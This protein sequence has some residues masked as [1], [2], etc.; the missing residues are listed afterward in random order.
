MKTSQ[1]KIVALLLMLLMLISTFTACKESKESEAP[2][3]KTVFDTALEAYNEISSAYEIVENYGSDI[4][5][6]WMSGIYDDDEMSIKFLSNETTLSES[7]LRAAFKSLWG[8]YSESTVFYLYESSDDYQMF[9]LCTSLV[10]E[11]YKLNGKADIVKE[12]LNKA[13]EIMKEMSN[14]YSDYEH[15]SNLKGFYTKTNAF[16]DYCEN[17]SGSFEQCKTTI[18]DYRNQIRDF[19]NDLDY[20]FEE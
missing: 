18:N 8:D 3:T 12:H 17:P 20:I 11:A 14:N 13:K 16:F 10:S 9:S 15:Y 4:Y 6:A 2:K 7:D 5:N 1:K 19:K